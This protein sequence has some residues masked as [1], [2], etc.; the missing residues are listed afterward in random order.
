MNVQ[1]KPINLYQLVLERVDEHLALQL[2][3]GVSNAK[4]NKESKELSA[5]SDVLTYPPV[6]YL[7]RTPEYITDIEKLDQGSM[8]WIINFVNYVT[9]DWCMMIRTMDGD[10]DYFD[11][12]IKSF[13]N[14]INGIVNTSVTMD[15]YT[16]RLDASKVKDPIALT[17]Y[18][19][20]TSYRQL[21]LNLGV[22]NGRATSKP[23]S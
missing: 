6:A 1:T 21:A 5:M 11:S 13:E 4:G 10:V 23:V 19:L 8:N 16:E 3:L 15:G 7:T 17:Y 20:A 9:M 14:T 22:A 18:M 12:F 2:E